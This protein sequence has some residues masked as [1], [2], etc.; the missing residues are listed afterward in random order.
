MQQH[1]GNPRRGMLCHQHLP[2][3]SLTSSQSAPSTSVLSALS[4]K[5]SHL[6]FSTWCNFRGLKVSQLFLGISNYI[7]SK[8]CQPTS[9]TGHVW[10]Q[11]D[12]QV[13]ARLVS[14]LKRLHH[15]RKRNGV[16]RRHALISG[17]CLGICLR[18]YSLFPW[19]IPSKPTPPSLVL[20][21]GLTARDTR[22]RSAKSSKAHSETDAAPYG[23]W[24]ARGK[25]KCTGYSQLQLQYFN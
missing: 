10:P 11:V 23:A 3:A 19:A 17:R 13:A 21:R 14:D 2:P 7:C 22:S 16:R 1:K 4:G 12:L 5:H 6:W 20:A 8:G 18:H 9:S 25:L 15:S 24:L